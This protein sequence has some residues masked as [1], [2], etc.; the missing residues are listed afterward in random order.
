MKL[1]ISLTVLFTT[2]LLL[3]G[4]SLSVVVALNI[5][6]NRIIA[7]EKIKKTTMNQIIW[8][9]LPIDN[10][11]VEYLNLNEKNNVLYL[12]S[13]SLDHDNKSFRFLSNKDGQLLSQN[14]Q[15]KI[16]YGEDTNFMFDNE[17]NAYTLL[18]DENENA[19]IYNISS[20]L[21]SFKVLLNNFKSDPSISNNL[22]ITQDKTKLIAMLGLEGLLAINI[23]ANNDKGKIAWKI[24]KGNYF[25][26]G[27]AV[28]ENNTN[29]IY[30]S[31]IHQ[32]HKLNAENGKE[33]S[34]F[35]YEANSGIQQFILLNDYLVFVKDTTNQHNITVTVYD[36][37]KSTLIK[38]F[39]VP[40]SMGDLKNSLSLLVVPLANN[41]FLISTFE[42][43]V[44][45]GRES[46]TY[47]NSII[48]KYKI[49]KSNNN[50]TT[51]V[52]VKKLDDLFCD[53]LISPF[54]DGALITNNK[55]KVV[56][57]CMKTVEDHSENN[58]IVVFD[59]LHASL[60]QQPIDND[61]C[62]TI[63]DLT[64][65]YLYQCCHKGSVLDTSTVCSA[66]SLN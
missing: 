37:V 53:T 28:Q 20:N 57:E 43:T 33:I 10:F 61:R 14:Y 30:A 23:A 63:T 55:N 29:I 42:I 11:A 60:N 4:S 39:I 34:V 12:T 36:R 8:R 18:T 24:G 45:G 3:V 40:N 54:I 44:H 50:I 26:S 66:L 49:I 19:N 5:N 35:P 51:V 56:L 2:I 16:S 6:N 41:E 65:R 21:N 62:R 27:I 15:V 31:S 38:T 7:K 46:A 59:S 32:L 9:S 17:G 64:N 1:I 58:V 48:R 22:I 25:H 47:S 13:G 52:F